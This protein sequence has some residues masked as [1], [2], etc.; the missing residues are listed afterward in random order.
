MSAKIF[1]QD[2][3]FMLVEIAGDALSFQTVSRTGLTVDSGTIR[4]GHDERQS[5]SE[6]I[7]N[8]LLALPLGCVLALVWANTL[9][10]SYYGFSNA[11]SFSVNGI[12][13]VFFFALIAKEVVEATVPAARSIRSARGA[14]IV[15]AIGG[16]AVAIASYL[17]VLWW[18]MS[19]APPHLGVACAVD[20]PASYV[21]MRWI[22]ALVIR[23][24]RFSSC[25]RFQP[26]CS[27]DPPG[28]A[29]VYRPAPVLG[30]GS[31]PPPSPGFRPATDGVKSFWFTCSVRESCPGF[32]LF[33]GGAHPGLAL[34]PIV[35]F[36]PHARHDAGS[37]VDA[38]SRAPGQPP[39]NLKRWWQVP[40]QGVL[41]LFGLVNAVCRST[42]WKAACGP[43]WPR[44][45]DAARIIAATGLGLAAG[46]TSRG[47]PGELGATWWS[48]P[49]PHPSDSSFALFF[50]RS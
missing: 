43:W 34:V 42:V 14:P 35:P 44:R 32:A 30:W 21:I 49:A 2:Q 36:F 23:P 9:P 20:I 16:C 12:G 1:D 27:G 46:L 40:V 17:L 50:R 47:P 6:F 45:L 4:R 10:E 28:S 7:L 19:D 31:W 13:M 8:Y 37:F 24:S 3:S 29:A 48:P 39:R 11:L 15:L 25:W 33:L 22:L 18:R 26:T 38:P 5:L 41:L